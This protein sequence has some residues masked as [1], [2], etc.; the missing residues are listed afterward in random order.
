VQMQS[1]TMIAT[2]CGKTI[3]L[4]VGVVLFNLTFLV[5]PKTVFDVFTG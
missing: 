2:L 1:Y 3:F 4:V 5:K